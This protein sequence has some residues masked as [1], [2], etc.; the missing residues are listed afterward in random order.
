MSLKHFIHKTKAI[1]IMK[2]K[3]VVN[4]GKNKAKII[5]IMTLKKINDFNLII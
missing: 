3:I 2:K 1:K 4:S 5:I